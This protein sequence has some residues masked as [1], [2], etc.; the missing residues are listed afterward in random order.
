MGGIGVLE[1]P[2]SR[3]DGVRGAT[4]VQHGGGQQGDARM[5]VLVVVPGEE[6][7]AEAQGVVVASEAVR[8]LGTVL[9]GLELA[10]RKGI[11]VGDVR[12]A[13]RLGHAQGGQ[14][15]RDALGAHRGPPVAVDGQLVALDALLV[16]GLADQP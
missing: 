1:D 14:Q 8:E 12:P 9:H 16:Y 15:L 6:S 2:A 10:F 11:V 7:S 13:V 3:L 5:V 4:V